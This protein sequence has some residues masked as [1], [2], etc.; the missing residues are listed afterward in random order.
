MSMRAEFHAV[1]QMELKE[2]FAGLKYLLK[3]QGQLVPRHTDANIGVVVRPK[4]PRLSRLS[5]SI[6]TLQAR[7]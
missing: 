2:Q 5:L 7:L 4:P 1:T 3:Q 6:L